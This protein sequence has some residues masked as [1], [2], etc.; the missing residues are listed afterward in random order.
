MEIQNISNI[1]GD[2]NINLQH[3]TAHDIN[4][5]TGKEENPEVKAKKEEI[6]NRIAE[7]IKKLDNHQKNNTVASNDLSDEGLEDIDFENL[8]N[9]IQY[10]NCV[11][12]I[13]PELS[14]NEEG[15]SIHEKFYESNGAEFN[16]TEG[17]FMPGADKKLKSK[18]MK[19]YNETFHQE[20]FRGNEILEKIAQIPFNL[21]ISAAPDDTLHRI[22]ERNNKP[23]QFLFFD[24]TKQQVQEPDKANPVVFNF[25][26][27]PAV[28]GKYIFT[29]Q[30]FHDY[31][32]EKLEVKIPTEI[33]AKVKEAEHYIFLG[34]DFAKWYNRLLLFSFNLETDGYAFSPHKMEKQLADYYKR[35]FKISCIE[36]HFNHFVDYLL[37]KTH[38]A[39]LTISLSEIFVKNTAQALQY[40]RVR[41][42]DMNKLVDLTNLEKELEQIVKLLNC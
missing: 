6:A 7:L 32:N 38:E 13:G 3:I 33:E 15:K 20:N 40:I 31:I 14:M 8:T 41:A 34:F 23:H 42:V 29:H 25:L 5:I 24:G 36:K 19:Y 12:F 18:I 30:Q 4:I 1:L 28:N 27:N 2:H 26:G 35:Q 9:A 16:K 22:F 10:E 17:F 21:I 37:Q 11:L 39:S